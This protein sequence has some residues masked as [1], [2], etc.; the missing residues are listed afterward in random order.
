MNQ[1]QAPRNQTSLRLELAQE[2]DLRSY[3]QLVQPVQDRLFAYAFLLTGSVQDAEDCLQRGVKSARDDLAMMGSAN[4]E[5]FLLR[6]VRRETLDLL[7]IRAYEP[8]SRVDR[9]AGAAT[10]EEALEVNDPD[11]LGAIAMPLLQ[12]LASEE[13]DCFVLAVALGLSP[14]GLEYVTGADREVGLARLRRALG[15][16]KASER[17]FSNREAT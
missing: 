8:Q 7:S 17:V 9:A 6:H 3:V 14:E 2:G 16:L 12:G 13:R 15:E 11:S 4:M 10:I 5:R 1:E